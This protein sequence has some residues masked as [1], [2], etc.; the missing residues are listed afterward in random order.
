MVKNSQI[1]FHVE[2]NILNYLKEQAK[3]EGISLSEYCRKQSLKG[4]QLDLQSM[5]DLEW[6]HKKVEVKT[7]R[8][9]EYGWRF[10]I[11]SKQ[12]L[13]ADYLLVFCLNTGREIIKIYLIPME[14]IK[15]KHLCRFHSSSD[16]LDPT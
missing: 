5:H 15:T 9:K 10:T 6:Q 8:F 11:G 2:T 4:S 1:H 12:K 7:A 13:E 14:V 3:K 16:M